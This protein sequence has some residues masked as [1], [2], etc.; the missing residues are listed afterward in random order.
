VAITIDSNGCRRAGSPPP[1]SAGR[2]L[3]T[4]DSFTFGHGVDDGET[5]SAQLEKTLGDSEVMNAGC[6][7]TGHDQHYLLVRAWLEAGGAKRPDQVIWGFSS[8]DFPRNTVGFRRLVDPETGLDYGKP[9]FVLRGGKLEL[10]H[11][12]TPE[13]AR[14]EAALHE[15]VAARERTHNGVARFFRRSRAI[16]VAWDMAVD[17]ME[18]MPLARALAVSFVEECKSRQVPLVIVNLPTRRWLNTRNPLNRLKAR[19]TDSLLKELADKHGARVVDCTPAFL[20][21]PD[22]DALFIPDGHYSAAG[23]AVVAG[24]IADELARGGATP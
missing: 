15:W 6:V 24:V 13:P 5:F 1:A 12:P 9:R 3:V 14:V 20:A 21:A 11:V 22:L 17:K 10:T 23:H 7:G 4:G 16:R 18:Q 8:A 19:L 2:I